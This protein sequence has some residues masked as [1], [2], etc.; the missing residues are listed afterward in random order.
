MNEAS[1]SP[2][3]VV[4][5]GVNVP[6]SHLPISKSRDLRAGVKRHVLTGPK[7]GADGEKRT[8]DVRLT[9]VPR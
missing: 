5:Y 1:P 7:G 6:R 2:V 9:L 3:G 4:Q 8:H